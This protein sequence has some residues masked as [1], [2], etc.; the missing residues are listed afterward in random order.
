M[1]DY[2]LSFA[3]REDA[4]ASCNGGNP[5]FATGH[6]VDLGEPHVAAPQPTGGETFSVFFKDQETIEVP[7]SAT[8]VNVYSPGEWSPPD[9]RI[10]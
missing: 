5:T 8:S 6:E 3:S 7:A 9:R 4:L 10:E 2:C 1:I